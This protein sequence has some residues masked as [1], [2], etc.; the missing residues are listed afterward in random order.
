LT[1][2]SACPVIARLIKKT[3]ADAALII[4]IKNLIVFTIQ[5]T[6]RTQSL[7]APCGQLSHSGLLAK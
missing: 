1:N 6:C 3:M 7:K 5:N 2:G 4:L